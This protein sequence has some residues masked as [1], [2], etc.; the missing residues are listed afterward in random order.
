MMP[1]VEVFVLPKVEADMEQN[2][3]ILDID[4][5]LDGKAYIYPPHEDYFLFFLLTKVP[6]TK[7]ELAV[8]YI[9][10]SNEGDKES[11]ITDL[12]DRSN[13]FGLVRDDSCIEWCEKHEGTVN[14]IIYKGKKFI[15]H[16][17]IEYQE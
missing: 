10:V 16:N 2:P 7:D 15:L 3:V 17:L 11:V 8:V 9:C 1:E 4:L 13:G 6:L 12:T 14:S 5:V